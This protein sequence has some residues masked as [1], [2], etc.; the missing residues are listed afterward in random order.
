LANPDGR[1]K[2]EGTLGKRLKKA[3]DV[4]LGI[5]AF[6]AFL[7]LPALFFAGADWLSQRLLPWFV[8]ASLLA[9]VL[10]ILVLLP[11]SAFR[12]C[13]GF[14]S[15]AMLIVSYVFGATVWIDG[16]VLTM[17]LWGTWAVFIGL[18]FAGVGIVPMAMLATL[19]KGMWGSLATL[20]VLTVVTFGTRIFAMWVAEKAEPAG[21]G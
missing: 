12:R 6:V 14:T 21:V 15:I 20:V 16:F 2:R 3:G 19:F 10:L 5:L 9:F 13:R 8:L 4:L 17:A 18:L 7:A 1:K 11:L